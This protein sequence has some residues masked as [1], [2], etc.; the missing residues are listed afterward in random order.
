MQGMT[1]AE[2]E[3]YVA[4]K[5]AERE[6]IQ[7]KIRDLSQKRREQDSINKKIVNCILTSTH[8]K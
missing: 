8:L 1:L 7:A 2:R 3:T 4:T 6:Q 5:Q